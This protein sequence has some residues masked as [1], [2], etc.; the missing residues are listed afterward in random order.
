MSKKKTRGTPPRR[1]KPAKKTTA[2]TPK[3]H[4]LDAQVVGDLP[5][6]M[7]GEGIELGELGLVELKLTDEEE[8]VLNEPP[9]IDRL[10]IMPSADGAVYAPHTEYTKLFNRAFGRL[11]WS[12]VPVGK[13]ALANKTVVCPYILFIHK[14]PVAFAQG[15][16][17]FFDNNKGQSY[18]DA[19]EST[20]ASGLRRCAK[21]IGVWLELWDRQ[22]ADAFRN[23]H[24]VKVWVEGKDG[25]KARPQWRL[26]TD[27]PFWNEKEGRDSQQR[28]DERQP[29]KADPPA[30][31]NPDDDQPI[32]HQQREHLVRIAKRAQRSETEIRMWLK[33]RFG[34]DSSA[35]LKRRDFEFVCKAIE[36]PGPLPGVREP[37]AEG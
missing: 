26:K 18:G 12:I 23:T 15:E 14:S 29:P 36:H 28:S 5:S 16:Q 32:T 20:V 1:K 30:G 27:P 19:L 25:D 9:P 21:R 8:R 35:A 10:K 11:G 33:V 7:I 6:R 31:H 2:L 34:V 37:G 22:W 24:G 17:E 3:P 13:P 4:V